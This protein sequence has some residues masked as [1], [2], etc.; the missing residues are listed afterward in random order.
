MPSLLRLLYF[1]LDF[2]CGGAA[3]FFTP[4]PGAPRRL[5]V[6]ERG[7]WDMAVDPR[8]YRLGL[9]RW[10]MLV[11]GCVVPRPDVLIVLD[12]P[13][14]VFLS[15]KR[16]LPA[17]ELERQRR[18]WRELRIPGVEKVILD[19]SKPLE[20]V[21]RDARKAIVAH[22]ERRAVARLGAGWANL[23]SRTR[24]RWW[25]PRR[26]RRT[27]VAGLGVYQPVTPKGRAGW[28]VARFLARVGGFRLLPRGEAPPR[29]VRERLAEHLP[30]RTT[31]AV[32]RANHPGRY[33]ALIVGEDGAARAV[34]KIA[35]TPEGEE[36]LRQEARAIERWGP[37]LPPPV[38]AP[39]I[40]REGEGVLLLETAP[41]RPRLRPWL[42]D[43]VVAAALGV[44]EREGISHGD[45]TPWNLLRTP[46]GFVLVDWESTGSVPVP[47]WDLWHWL[48]QSHVLLGRPRRVELLEA[49]RG[50]GRLGSSARAFLR[51][52]GLE[53]GDLAGF[54]R[55]YLV[56]SRDGLNPSAPAGQRGVA[57]REAILRELDNLPRKGV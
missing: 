45:A 27:A 42:L 33:V 49:L 31:Y 54:L 10:F 32:M 3:R 22:L 41:S 16:E 39:R 30:P 2:M 18:A 47:G 53:C 1:W 44:L 13:A 20:E 50:A 51:T 38:R 26:P 56:C 24:I 12:A 28:E 17:E 8:R 11:L 15:R 35:T 19:A 48:V 25:L 5:F 6:M 21:V 29:E 14:D 23:P 46:D 43:P 7:W 37:V 57:A 40:I 4:R 9:P 52:A 55:A 36:C 34:A